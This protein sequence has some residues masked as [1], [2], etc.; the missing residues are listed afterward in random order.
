MDQIT[1]IC[2]A[3]FAAAVLRGLTGFGFALAAVPAL[4]LFLDPAQA[5][6]IAI[7][8]QCMVGLRD[9]ALMRKL[10]QFRALGLMGAGALIGTPLGIWGLTLLPADVMRLVLAGIVGIG[11]AALILKTRLPPGPGPAIGAGFASGLF[12]GLA[13]M[14]GPPAIAYF[15]GTET[16]AKQTRASLMVFFFLTSLIAMPG[17]WLTGRLH[18]ETFTQA[19]IA[20][21]AL[22][23]GTWAGGRAFEKLGEGGYRTAATALLGVT[24]AVTATRGLA[25]LL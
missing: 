6:T 15:L 4:S 11:L 23:I 13:A 1:L 7:L 21:P 3:V 9:L 22:L 25:G 17:L 2:T 19:L 12:S 18:A 8:L 14:P 24:A 5:V 10:V 20:F 16:P